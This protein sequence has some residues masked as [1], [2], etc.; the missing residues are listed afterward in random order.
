[1]IMVGRDYGAGYD[2]IA[3]PLTDGETEVMFCPFCGDLF[4]QLTT[5]GLGTGESYNMTVVGSI[6]NSGWDNL[7]AA[8]VDTTVSAD[9]TKLLLFPGRVPTY[10]KL[11]G[12]EAT[13]VSITAQA[14]FSIMS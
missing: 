3:L 11:T 9:G 14:Y 8:D 13:G 6:D 10:V 5:S 4:V 1:M 12:L 7:D 2:P